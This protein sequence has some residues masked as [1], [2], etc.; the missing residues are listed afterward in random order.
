M[1]RWFYIGIGCA[2]IAALLYSESVRRTGKEP[3]AHVAS[4]PSAELSMPSLPDLDLPVRGFGGPVQVFYVGHA[5]SLAEVRAAVD[6]ERIIAETPAGFALQEGRIVTL[7]P[8]G[9]AA[10]L[11]VTDWSSRP[12]QIHRPD[13]RLPS[14]RSHGPFGSGSGKQAG[15]PG[16]LM[17]KSHLSRAE[18][19]A[20]MEQLQ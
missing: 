10:L 12:I 3:G 9:A 8:E 4:L 20:V 16:D 14:Y 19:N 7:G 17:G 2:V 18:A 11:A 6:P 15:A 5:E 1:L 13:P